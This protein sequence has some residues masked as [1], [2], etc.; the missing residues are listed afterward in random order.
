MAVHLLINLRALQDGF[1]CIDHDHV[2]AHVHEGSPL[3]ISLAGQNEAT[4]EAR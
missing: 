2:I 3:R 4:S 1:A